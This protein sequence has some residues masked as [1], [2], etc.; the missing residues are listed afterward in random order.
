MRSASVEVQCTIYRDGGISWDISVPCTV[1]GQ[2]VPAGRHSP[3]EYPEVEV[4]L[5]QLIIDEGWDHS[6]PAAP[7]P[8][9]VPDDLQLTDDERRSVVARCEHEAPRIAQDYADSL[10]DAQRRPWRQ[11]RDWV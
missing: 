7:A 9:T 8:L 5:H 10:R 2:R 6:D 3:P 4:H 11:E 1:S